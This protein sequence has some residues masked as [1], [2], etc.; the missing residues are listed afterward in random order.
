MKLYLQ[1][2]PREKPYVFRIPAPLVFNRLG[3][4]ILKCGLQ[5]N[6]PAARRLHYKMFRPLLRCLRGFQKQGECL[7]DANLQNNVHISLYF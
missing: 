5:K 6:L 4:F 1:I 2:P 7:L 3:F